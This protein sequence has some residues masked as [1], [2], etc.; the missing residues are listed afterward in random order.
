MEYFIGTCPRLLNTRARRKLIL[1]VVQ[2]TVHN[3]NGIRQSCNC[4]LRA[5]S[6]EIFRKKN[7]FW[8][9]FRLFFSWEQKSRCSG[10][11]NAYSHYSNYFYSGLIPNERTL[12]ELA[13]IIRSKRIHNKLNKKAD[14]LYINAR[15]VLSNEHLL[16]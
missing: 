11:R 10:M 8:H 15:E 7:K 9:I 2:Q 5:R 4:L 16:L 14:D 13:G 12:N 6:F 1:C 3:P